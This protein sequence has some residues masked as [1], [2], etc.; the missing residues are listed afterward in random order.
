M[1][2]EEEAADREKDKRKVVLSSF[3]AKALDAQS[4]LF[5][6]GD[7]RGLFD[8]RKLSHLG[9]VS[10]SQTFYFLGSLS[11]CNTVLESAPWQQTADREPLAHALRGHPR[12]EVIFD[13]SSALLITRAPI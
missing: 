1:V 12:L 13:P 3:A 8:A 10:A 7:D 2:G 9:L 4:R 11:S 6:L 5:D